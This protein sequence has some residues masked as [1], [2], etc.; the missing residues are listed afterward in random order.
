MPQHLKTV[1]PFKWESMRSARVCKAR[2]SCKTLESSKWATCP[3]QGSEMGWRLKFV[4]TQAN[5]PPHPAC[6]TSLPGDRKDLKNK[7][8]DSPSLLRHIP[9][10]PWLVLA[11][12]LRFWAKKTLRP[13]EGRLGLQSVAR[14]WVLGWVLPT[15]LIKV[16]LYATAQGWGHDKS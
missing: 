5:T 4:W 8:S 3:Q 2:A 7:P 11:C 14:G 10:G 13:I 16:G 1:L 15:F 9:H 6:T 12:R